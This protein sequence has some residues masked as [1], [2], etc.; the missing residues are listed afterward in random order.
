MPFLP[1]GLLRVPALASQRPKGIRVFPWV[2]SRRVRI[3]GRPA[4]RHTLTVTRAMIPLGR[5]DAP[6]VGGLQRC[7]VGRTLVVDRYADGCIIDVFE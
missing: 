3:A 4:W 1:E 5:S 2:S 7:D 6:G